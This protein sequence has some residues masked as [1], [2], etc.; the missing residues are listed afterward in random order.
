MCVLAICIVA[1]HPARDSL[2]ATLTNVKGIGKLKLCYN[3]ITS[4]DIF[5]RHGHCITHFNV[6]VFR[7]RIKGVLSSKIKYV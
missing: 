2:Y 4:W 5:V 6:R 7:T 1:Q 3:I